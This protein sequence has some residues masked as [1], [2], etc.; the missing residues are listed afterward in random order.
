M[1]EVYSP[2]LV[3]PANAKEKRPL[4]AG[5][6]CTAIL[7]NIIQYCPVLSNIVQER[8]VV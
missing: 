8:R 4:L 6:H 2:V 3:N 7:F 5:K 1:A